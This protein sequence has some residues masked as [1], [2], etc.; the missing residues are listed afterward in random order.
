MK[1]A[2]IPDWEPASA[3][4]PFE[5]SG[6]W[7]LWVQLLGMP[8]WKKKPISAIELACKQ[9]KRFHVDFAAMLVENSIVGNYQGVV[10]PD[11]AQ[12]YEV[13]KYKNE[14]NGA[15]QINSTATREEVNTE[16]NSRNYNN[17]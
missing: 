5:D 2:K 3:P 8:K 6:F 9:L 12:R 11:T 14:K 16:F 4:C 15:K 17:R 7:E 1:K 13:W 10:F